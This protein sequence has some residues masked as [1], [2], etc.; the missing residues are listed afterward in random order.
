MILVGHGHATAYEYEDP[1]NARKKTGENSVS[2]ELKVDVPGMLTEDAATRIQSL[3]RR[4]ANR[5]A[6]VAAVDQRDQKRAP[7]EAARVAKA[8]KDRPVIV[9]GAG[10]KDPG[11][12]QVLRGS[13]I[14]DGKKVS[15]PRPA[16]E[17]R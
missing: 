9:L 8:P 2:I 3:L 14:I 1:H 15:A 6:E 16:R 10:T 5:I 7:I 17:E 11:A 4:E 12:V 13:Y